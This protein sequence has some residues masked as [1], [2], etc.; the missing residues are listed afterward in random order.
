MLGSISGQQYSEI[1]QREKIHRV[2]GAEMF[3]IENDWVFMC[4]D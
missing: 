2:I 4:W 1:L 3:V